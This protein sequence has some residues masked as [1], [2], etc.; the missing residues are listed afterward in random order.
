MTY[1]LWGVKAS[2]APRPADLRHGRP[3]NELAGL[4]KRQ[5]VPKNKSVPEPAHR[6]SIVGG[7]PMRP[8]RNILALIVRIVSADP[9][10]SN[11]GRHV[12]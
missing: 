12:I 2:P 11:H 8:A 9:V 10:Y 7:K 4:L 3:Q 5:H 1:S 6:P